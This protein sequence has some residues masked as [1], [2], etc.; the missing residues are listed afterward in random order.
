MKIKWNIPEE[1]CVHDGCSAKVGEPSNDL[2]ISVPDACFLSLMEI[3]A[4]FA[5]T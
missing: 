2:L 5:P 1:T 3:L 4:N